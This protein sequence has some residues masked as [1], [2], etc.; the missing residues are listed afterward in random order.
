MILPIVAYGSPILRKTAVNISPDYPDLQ[1][2]INNMWE[3]LYASSG[4]GLAAPQIDHS[5][6]LFVI[7]A[8]PYSIEDPQVASFKEVFINAQIIE[9]KGETLPFN[10]GCL[11]LPDIR[12][13]VTRF[14]EIRIKYLD[15]NFQPHDK[16]LYGIAAR[17]VQHEYDHLDGKLFIDYLNNL[18][19]IM[20]KSKLSDISKGK[21]N[22]SYK[23]KFPLSTKTK[24]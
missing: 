15:E 23:M 9:K 7:D 2:L 3:T 10:E 24:K 13:D 20:L 5:I 6:R 18:K 19:K 21:I 16:I 12:E 22:V 1:N 14:S 8:S 4:V 17:V 11:S